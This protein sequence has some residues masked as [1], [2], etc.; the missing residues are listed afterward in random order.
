MIARAPLTLPPYTPTDWELRLP[1]YPIIGNRWRSTSLPD[2]LGSIPSGAEWRL[3]YE[4]R[5]SDE[6]LALLLPWRATGGGQW[7]LTPLPLETAYGVDDAEFLKRL[8][9][10]TWTIAR[11]P[12]KQA[13]KKGRFNITI[14]LI[15]EL[16]FESNYRIP[17]ANATGFTLSVV[18]SFAGGVAEGNLDASATGFDLSIA[19]SFTGGAVQGNAGANATGF[20]LVVNVSFVGE[21]NFGIAPVSFTLSATPAGIGLGTPALGTAEASASLQ[22]SVAPASF[23]L[24]ATPAGI[25]LGL[26]AIGTANPTA[27]L[28]L[29]VAPVNLS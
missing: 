12:Q 15:Y 1:G 25:S 29:S 6:T 19:T 14:E 17:V 4:N 20:A 10:T 18:A 24:T 22:L 28:Q 13:V 11:E 23:T 5:T 8:I 7:P 3:T 2:A 21:I 16:T 9:G 26:L 27:S